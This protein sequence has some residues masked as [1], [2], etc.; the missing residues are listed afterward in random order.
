MILEAD[1]TSLLDHHRDQ[2]DAVTMLLLRDYPRVAD[3]GTIGVDGEG[4]VR[5]IGKRF[6]LGGESDC[7]V[8]TWANV[9]AARVFDSLPDR[10]AFSHLDDWWAPL[11]RDGA[12]DVRG[13]VVGPEACSWQPVGTPAEYLRVNFEPERLSYLDAEAVARAAGTRFQGD[14][15]IGAGATLGAGASLK[16]CVVWDGERVPAGLEARDGVFAGGNFHRFPA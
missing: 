12:R 7:G 4:C 6:D 1:L 13:V 9:V 10:D 2:R 15:V 5:R 3:F 8:Y 14:V 16:R 11:L